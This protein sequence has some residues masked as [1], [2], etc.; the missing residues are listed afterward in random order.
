MYYARVV[1]NPN[2][3][4]A[5]AHAPTVQRAE[6]KDVLLSSDGFTAKYRNRNAKQISEA[7][8]TSWAGRVF[9][10][11]FEHFFRIF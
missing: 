9:Y 3:R 11:S 4:V 2:S 10:S 7:R 6:G 1:I 5:Y 8:L